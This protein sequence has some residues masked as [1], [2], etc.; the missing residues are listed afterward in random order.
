MYV[1]VLKKM[2]GMG[3]EGGLWKKVVLGD[4]GVGSGKVRRGKC[5]RMCD[6]IKMGDGEVGEEKGRVWVRGEVFVLGWYGGRGLIERVWMRKGNVKV[7]EDG[8]KWVV[9]KGKKRGRVGRVKVV[10]EGLEVMGK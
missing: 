9:Y 6:L 5:V 10:G 2:W 8:E 4:Y 3:F 1:W 7:L